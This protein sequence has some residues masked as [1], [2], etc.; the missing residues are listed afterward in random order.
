MAATL[1]AIRTA[2]RIG[3]LDRT[4][5]SVLAIDPGLGAFSAYDPRRSQTV[6]ESLDAVLR[7]P[8]G[9][10]FA[11]VD[12]LT[13]VGYLLIAPVG[14]DQPWGRLRDPRILDIAI[15]VA[16]GYRSQAIA[17]SLLR[18]AFSRPQV[19]SRIYVATGYAWC[20]D[21]DGTRTDAATYARRLLRLFERFEFRHERTDEANIA[22]ILFNFLAVRIGWL[23]PADLVRKFRATLT[24]RWA[25]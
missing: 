22:M 18:R 1:D 10:V 17:Q 21:V 23:V 2:L 20:W 24:A 6:W 14:A 25:A 16:R 7:T 15:E 12:D 5:L 11:A 4:S 3:P 8:G 19:E 9:E 13:I